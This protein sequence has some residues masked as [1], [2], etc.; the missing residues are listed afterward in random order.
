MLVCMLLLSMYLTHV[1]YENIYVLQLE[2][3]Q[4]IKKVF[5]INILILFHVLCSFYILLSMCMTNKLITPETF[6]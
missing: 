5:S 3:R 6:Q 2:N 4:N 1:V